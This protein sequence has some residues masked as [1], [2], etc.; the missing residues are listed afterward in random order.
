MR[1]V[2]IAADAT[3]ITRTGTTIVVGLLGLVLVHWAL[4]RGFGSQREAGTRER[5]YRNQESL[6]DQQRDQR[7]A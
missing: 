5:M 2:A 7:K 4:G 1:I 6:N 3:S